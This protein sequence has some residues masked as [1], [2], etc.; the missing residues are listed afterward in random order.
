MEIEVLEH[1]SRGR[2]L[3]DIARIER[4]TP[5]AVHSIASRIYDKLGADN[6]VQAVIFAMNMHILPRA[7]FYGS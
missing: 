7:E 1:I 4:K 2:R 3:L 5:A 6:R